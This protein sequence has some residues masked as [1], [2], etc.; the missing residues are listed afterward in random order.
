MVVW[1]DDIRGILMN[2][3]LL[4]PPTCFT[5][6]LGEPLRHNPIQKEYSHLI[7]INFPVLENYEFK[8]EIM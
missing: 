8:I 4:Y 2:S 7:D 1:D 5:S 3:H 6:D